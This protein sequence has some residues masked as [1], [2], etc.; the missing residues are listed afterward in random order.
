MLKVALPG[1]AWGKFLTNKNVPFGVFSTVGAPNFRWSSGSKVRAGADSG[2]SASRKDRATTS[3]WR[4]FKT[5][6]M[7]SIRCRILVEKTCAL[8][9]IRCQKRE[10]LLFG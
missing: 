2:V 10:F 6:L 4:L 1:L 7:Q 5:P 9:F 8:C 3:A